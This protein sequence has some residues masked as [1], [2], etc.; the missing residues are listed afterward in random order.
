MPLTATCKDCN[1]SFE[2]PALEKDA[3]TG[4]CPACEETHKIKELTHDISK[5]QEKIDQTRPILCKLNKE[6]KAA[7][8][9]FIEAETAWEDVARK[10]ALVTRQHAILSHNLA[11]LQKKKEVS[12][13]RQKKKQKTAEELVNDLLKKLSPEAKAALLTEVQNQ[14]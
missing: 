2:Y 5:L 7:Q 8:V 12:K 10:Q 11:I 1:K 13:P 6:K 9:K 4:R 14:K 3:Q